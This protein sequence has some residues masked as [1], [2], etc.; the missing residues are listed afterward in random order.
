MVYVGTLLRTQLFLKE[1]ADKRWYISNIELIADKRKDYRFGNAIKACNNRRVDII[2][3][4]G[5]RTW[6][7]FNRKVVGFLTRKTIVIT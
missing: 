4:I 7:V 6:M 5:C 3:D 1:N 2:G